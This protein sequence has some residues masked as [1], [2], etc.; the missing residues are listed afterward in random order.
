MP[1]RLREIR[2]NQIFLRV[3]VTQC[4]KRNLAKGLSVPFIRN[5][6]LFYKNGNVCV[7][8]VTLSRDRFKRSSFMTPKTLKLNLHVKS[9][10]VR[11]VFLPTS[12]V[13]VCVCVCAHVYVTVSHGAAV[14][15]LGRGFQCTF[16]VQAW[17]KIQENSELIAQYC[18]PNE[19]IDD[20]YF[21]FHF[22][23]ACV[24]THN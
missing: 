23:R 8:A 3:F 14:I 4:F 10:E 6:L 16:R 22:V 5:G 18:G 24:C 17:Q 11:Q 12:P 20:T 13:C 7:S 1:V 15:R 19:T 21:H 9:G 2:F